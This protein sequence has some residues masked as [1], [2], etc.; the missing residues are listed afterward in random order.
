MRDRSSYKPVQEGAYVLDLTLVELEQSLLKVEVLLW[1]GHRGSA[2]SR[3]GAAISVLLSLV[4]TLT[5][6]VV[7]LAIPGRAPPA[8]APSPAA[9]NGAPRRSCKTRQSVR[10]SMIFVKS[11]TQRER[12]TGCHE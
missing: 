1:H 11:E 12:R 9:V 5:L 10:M 6:V 3:G 4:V 2:G 8:S 7:A